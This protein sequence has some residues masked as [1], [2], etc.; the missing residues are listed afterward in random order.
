MAW[1]LLIQYASCV[2]VCGG[3]CL[4]AHKYMHIEGS[5]R[6]EK[7]WT[8]FPTDIIQPLCDMSVSPKSFRWTPS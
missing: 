5:L 4:C 7:S 2:S 6:Q 1:C 3:V 8:G